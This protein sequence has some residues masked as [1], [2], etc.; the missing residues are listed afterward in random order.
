M[1]SDKETNWLKGMCKRK[2]KEKSTVI[3]GSLHDMFIDPE[4]SRLDPTEVFNDR[5]QDRKLILDE[6]E[7][8]ITKTLLRQLSQ[9]P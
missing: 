3:K 5:K 8:D 6:H 4:T 9:L 1:N 7:Q 2:K